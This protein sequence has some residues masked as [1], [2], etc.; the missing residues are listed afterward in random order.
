MTL[1]NIDLPYSL[2]TGHS[3]PVKDFFIPIL[4]NAKT[5]DV[6]V[7][8]FTS[9]WLRDTADGFAEFAM[10]GG[11]SRWIVSPELEQKDAIAIMETSKSYGSITNFHERELLSV[12]QSLRKDAREE[13]CAL[14]SAGVIDFQIA[15]PRV[16]GTGMFHAKLGVAS[17]SEENLVGFSG[18]YNLTA[19][20]KSNWEHLNIFKNW[21]DGEAKRVAH[22]QH[23]FQ[24]LWE[25]NDPRYDVF[26]P[27]RHLLRFVENHAGEQRRK[28]QSVVAYPKKLPPIKLRDYQKQ[29]VDSWGKN[30]GR[31][32]FA[33]ATGSGKTVTALATVRKLIE[34]VVEEKSKPL[35]IIIVLPLKHLLDQWHSEAIGF[36][37]DP[38]KCYEN[39]ATWRKK[40]AE[41]M[42]VLNV[43]GSGYI[44]ALVTNSTF[45]LDPF[46]AEMQRIDC[47]FLLVADE[48]HNLGSQTYLDALPSNANFRL[49]LSATPERHND[50]FGTD[51]LFHYFG[52]PVI[53][54]T[55]ED[56][57]NAGFLCPY[58]YHPHL[59]LLSE[60]EYEE[61]LAL[62]D[63]IKAEMVKSAGKNER[64]KE[65]NRLQGKRSDL[66]AG[67]ESKLV[68][69]E[70]LLNLQAETDGISHT[71]VYCG[72]RKGED[73]D[74][75]IERTL[76]LIGKL[77]IKARKFTASESM[78][79]RKEILKLF[80]AG[81][82]GAIAAI[83]CLDE[84]VDVPA[85]R[86][87]YILASTANPR[88][89]IQRRGRVL[90]KSEG[91]EI[92]VIHDF[93]VA[94][95]S[96][97]YREDDMVERELERAREFSSLALN[98]SECD[99]VL[100]ALAYENGVDGWR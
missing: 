86:V 79:D 97:K 19:G 72:S 50:I 62:S 30:N 29:A 87:A 40:L 34:K 66:I 3:D 89:Y 46:Q 80:S 95:P 64:T 5:Y 31:G 68:K 60:A 77:G 25:N 65:Y 7:G 24:S 36:G 52:D 90:R 44:M 82:L 15:I 14:I 23:L 17:D 20:A 33:M 83:K 55:L 73:N 28:Y 61:Y 67:V 2:S 98:R 78:E 39:S 10:S 49:A 9:G 91:K 88:E 75:H 74:R 70:M 71:L 92:A 26:R 99:A 56:A 96:K 8:Y 48:A 4:K 1:R 42:G 43:T 94:P 57:I 13:L 16:K 47:D 54:F 38:I 45:S 37:F 63:L 27:T 93:L 58:E 21:E 81:E 35:V 11:R 53:E 22:L 69:L 32:T 76:K 84:G 51:A 18:S 59:C 12:V 41:R 85:T 6:A 100:G